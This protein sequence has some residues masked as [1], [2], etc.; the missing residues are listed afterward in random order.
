M[1]RTQ[2]HIDK[3]KVITGKTPD[4]F[5]KLAEKKGFIVDGE[6]L[7]TIKAGEILNWLKEDFELGHG[8]AMAIY[9]TMKGK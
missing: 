7:P 3:D 9:H 5:K 8:Y 2:A 4:D 6:F 1:D